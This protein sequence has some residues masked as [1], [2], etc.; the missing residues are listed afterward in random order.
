MEGLAWDLAKELSRSSEIHVLTTTVPGRS[1]QFESDGIQVKTLPGTRPGRYSSKWWVKTAFWRQAR[2]YDAVLS[3]SAGASSMVR[4]NRSPRYVFQAHGTAFSELQAV[5]SGKPRLW[6]LKALRMSY[7]DAIDRGTYKLVDAVVPVSG[8]VGEKLNHPRYSRARAKTEFAVI[9]NGVLTEPTLASDG[10]ARKR[11]GLAAADDVVVCVSRLVRQKGVDRAIEALAASSADTKLLVVG[12]GPESGALR[13]YALYAGVSDRVV[14]TGQ[15]DKDGVHDA[16]RA[17]DAFVFPV[18][19]AQRE[20]LPL[21]VLEAIACGLPV[22]VPKDS[23]WDTDLVPC[24]RFTNVADPR[25]L[26]RAIADAVAAERVT[27]PA[28]YT[29]ESMVASYKSI[30]GLS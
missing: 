8:V 25:T 26:S 1:A 19:D 28:I 22:I 13:E 27:L 6:A 12:D 24:L 9:A 15:L 23:D 7:W 5:L 16:L 4:L 20:G 11:F 3:V 10:S 29:R 2:D 14:F 18:R 21:A 17:A 30:L